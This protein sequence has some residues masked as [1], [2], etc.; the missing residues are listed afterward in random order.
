MRKKKPVK[1]LIVGDNAQIVDI[2]AEKKTLLSHKTI[3][4]SNGEEA[5]QVASKQPP[6]DLLITD[7]MTPEINGVGFAEQFTKLYPKTNVLYRI[8]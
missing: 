5:L 3:K 4:V 8:F 6:F 7:I 1:V 2:A